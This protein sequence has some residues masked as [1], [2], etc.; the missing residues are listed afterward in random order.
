MIKNV[1]V[2]K[3]YPVKASEFKYPEH[4]LKIKNMLYRTSN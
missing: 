1:I 3:K 2:A 4:G